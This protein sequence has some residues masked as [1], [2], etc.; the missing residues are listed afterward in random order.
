[1]GKVWQIQEFHFTLSPREQL[2]VQRLGFDTRVTVL[3][4]VQGEDP[5]AFRPSWWWG[6]TLVLGVCTGGV[7]C[8]HARVHVFSLPQCSE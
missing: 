1:M 6:I 8:V 2:V 5:S 7:V 4:H 3:G